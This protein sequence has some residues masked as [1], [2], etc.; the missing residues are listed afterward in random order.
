ML[1]VHNPPQSFV[2]WGQCIYTPANMQCKIIVHRSIKDYPAALFTRNLIG[3][4]KRFA[5]TLPADN[6]LVTHFINIK[7]MDNSVFSTDFPVLHIHIV[8]YSILKIL[9][10]LHVHCFDFLPSHNIIFYCLASGIKIY[11]LWSACK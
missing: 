2:F 5:N 11:V 6:H 1:R 3:K 4:Y 9:H 7:Q 10:K 8:L